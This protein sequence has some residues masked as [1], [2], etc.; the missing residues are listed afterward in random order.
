[1]PDY[2]NTA[3]NGM[4]IMQALRQYGLDRVLEMQGPARDALLGLLENAGLSPEQIAVLQDY[5]G[6]AAGV[7]DQYTYNLTG[8]QAAIQQNLVG[9]GTDWVRNLLNYFGATPANQAGFDQGMNIAGGGT[10]PQSATADALYEMLGLRGRNAQLSVLG[11]RSGQLLASNGMTPSLDDLMGGG[12][13]LLAA[14]GRTPQLDQLSQLLTGAFGKSG[15]QGQALISQA[16]STGGMTPELRALFG[17]A[18]SGLRA[19]GSNPALDE[20]TSRALDIIRAGGQGGALIP[21]EQAQSMARDEAITAARGQQEAVVR[22]ALA[23][24]GGPGSRTSGAQMR[25]LAEFADQSAQ[26]EAAAIREATKT[27]Q[28]LQLQ[29]LLGAFGEGNKAQATV[30]SRLGT[31]GRLGGDTADAAARMMQALLSGGVSLEGLQGDFGR[32]LASLEGIAGQNMATGVNAAGTA[33]QLANARSQIGANLGLG[34][35]QQVGTNMSETA[36]NLLSLIQGQT[37]GLNAAAQFS[38]QQ[39][40]GQNDL[41]SLLLGL[42]NTGAGMANQAGAQGVQRGGDINQILT[43]ILGGRA[44]VAQQGQNNIATGTQGLI[45]AGNPWISFAGQTIPAT[46]QLMQQLM[47]I[48]SQ[49]GFWS[50]LAQTALTGL[51]GGFTGSLSFPKIPGFGGPSHTGAPAGWDA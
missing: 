6:T 16:L 19:G 5:R 48:Q 10:K 39:V 44:N 51:I 50:Q 14:G 8:P 37:G 25:P 27:Q 43:A 41:L 35:E 45:S 40:A 7:P 29:Q 42:T 33:G 28:T 34:I 31:F 22:R 30:A 36:R 11:D 3:T 4:N 9:P 46:T 2:Q 18:L 12:L 47:Q 15:Q 13:G 49:P 26:A 17:E 23:L 24:G 20:M 21:M 38:G 1:M 32:A